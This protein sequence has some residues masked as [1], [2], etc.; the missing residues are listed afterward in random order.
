MYLNKLLSIT[1][2]SET[3][4]IATRRNYHTTKVK[5]PALISAEVTT[6][7]NAHTRTQGNLGTPTTSSPLLASTGLRTDDNYVTTTQDNLFLTTKTNIPTTSADRSIRRTHKNTITPPTTQMSL[8]TAIFSRK[9][10]STY[11]IP[12]TTPSTHSAQSSSAMTAFYQPHLL[13][14]QHPPLIAQTSIA[15]SYLTATTTPVTKLTQRIS[16]G[17]T[18]AADR[19]DEE[20]QGNKVALSRTFEPT[21]GVQTTAI[22]RDVEGPFSQNLFT[23]PTSKQ[24]NPTA[25]M[26]TA[27]DQLPADQI[28]V[29]DE[30]GYFNVAPRKSRVEEQDH[31][32]L[33]W[34]V[35]GSMTGGFALVAVVLSSVAI[36]KLK[37][38]Y[39]NLH[40]QAMF[41]SAVHPNKTLL[42]PTFT[43]SSKSS[44]VLRAKSLKTGMIFLRS[45]ILVSHQALQGSSKKLPIV[46]YF[47][48]RR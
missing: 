2:T 21:N 31:K 7:T 24:P 15:R 47:K 23:H 42:F 17:S 22:S 1:E 45:I 43:G 20:K 46:S 14:T 44:T 11:S 41:L 29:N 27:L 19:S 39:A 30:K 3:T 12:Q 36:S 10:E 40:S 38:R 32:H 4:T 34:I 37:R 8:T 9:S 16:R 33:E 35:A 6:N 13:S 26:S 28:Q 18:W 5:T 48:K 25:K